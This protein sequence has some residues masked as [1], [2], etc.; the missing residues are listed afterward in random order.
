M[1]SKLTGLRSQIAKS[2]NQTA[3]W[4]YLPRTIAYDAAKHASVL[5]GNTMTPAVTIHEEVIKAVEAMGNHQENNP[6]LPAYRLVGIRGKKDTSVTYVLEYHLNSDETLIVK[7]ISGG[8]MT[9]SVMSQISGKLLIQSWRMSP[10]MASAFILLVIPA[11][12]AM[13]QEQGDSEL[14]NMIDMLES[15][16][17]DCYHYTCLNDF[18]ETVIDHIAYTS[19]IFE[20]LSELEAEFGSAGVPEMIPDAELTKKFCGNVY[21]ENRG[22]EMLYVMPGGKVSIGTARSTITIAEAKTMFADFSAHRAWTQ[23]EKDL[24]PS[25][26]DDMPVMPEALFF[27]N[28]FAGTRDDRTP[29]K[30]VMWRGVTAYGKSTGTEQVAAILQMPLLRHTCSPEME[31]L[32]L[33]CQFVPNTDTT[34]Q[35]GMNHENVFAGADHEPDPAVAE[36]IAY[37]ESLPENEKAEILKADSFYEAAMF[38]MEAAYAKLT[39]KTVD[40]ADPAELMTLYTKTCTAY[41]RS[42]LAKSVAA[43]QKENEQLQQD[44]KA[45]GKE[46]RRTQFKMV[47]ANYAQ[48][49]R[50]GWIVELQEMSRVRDQGVFV[51]LNE[52]DRPG[53]KMQ[54]VD[55]SILTR[56][57]DAIMIATDNIGLESCRQIDASVRRRF[58]CI[59]DSFQ[60]D[61]QRMV[62]RTMRNTGCKDMALL[63]KAYACWD[64]I[65]TFCVENEVSGYCVSAMEYERLVQ[66]VMHDG[67]DSFE[68]NLNCCIISKA[69]DD[70]EIQSDIHG[71]LEAIL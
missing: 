35:P 69:T 54:L 20:M 9:A 60:L 58:A 48:A 14:A 12:A 7:W 16:L 10:T 39:G 50:N 37:L 34:E 68:E 29:I 24:I 55:G 53:A 46:P 49:M 61:K 56:H 65:L 1:K 4:S 36:V 52:L 28:K 8:E 6:N 63:E 47:E 38:D 3:P 71:V 30:N 43:L 21:C 5:R 32:D 57:K 23:H 13:E 33:L 26:P 18:P 40:Y 19:I 59:V 2:K 25:L 70:M 67:P 64:A 45:S 31:R 17:P 44:L 41:V 62:E 22:D 42:S 27:C 11:I 66:A 15:E 51:G